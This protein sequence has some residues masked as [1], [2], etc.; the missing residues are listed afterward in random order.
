MALEILEQRQRKYIKLFRE[1]Y[2]KLV[3]QRSVESRQTKIA[4]EDQDR[5]L[6][7]VDYLHT[8]LDQLRESTDDTIAQLEREKSGLESNIEKLAS[9]LNEADVNL[10]REKFETA[11]ERT[12]R[13]NYIKDWT[14]TRQNL[15]GVIDGTDPDRSK[16][17][18]LREILL[19]RRVGDGAQ[20]GTSKSKGKS[21]AQ[22]PVP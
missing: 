15:L 16:I 20:A 7:V 1:F 22:G 5:A 2:D 6:R 21:K 9:W 12:I 4:V 13:E 14:H 19:G 3:L 17:I 18:M 11:D 8:Q 10:R